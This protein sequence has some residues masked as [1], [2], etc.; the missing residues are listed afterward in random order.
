MDARCP[1][2]PA[3]MSDVLFTLIVF[4]LFFLVLGPLV[5]Y[6]WN[7]KTISIGGTSIRITDTEDT[8]DTE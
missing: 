8:E 6:F 1:P 5:A 7:G 4:G 2:T 3:T